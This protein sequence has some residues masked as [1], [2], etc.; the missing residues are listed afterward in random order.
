MS[1]TWLATSLVIGLLTAGQ[2]T[3]AQSVPG[4]VGSWALLNAERIDEAAPLP[5]ANARGLIIMDSAGHV[6]EVVTRGR[7][8]PYVKNQ[9]TPDE[10]LE[11][12]NSYRGFWGTYRA[13]EKA[14]R[15]EYRPQGAVNPNLMGQEL[16]RDYELKGD[17][18]TITSR[19]GDADTT[20]P[21]R[22]V[23]Q[24]IPP[25][26]NLSPAYRQV[27]GFWQWVGEKSVATATGATVTEGK[28]DPSI[29]VYAPS[30]LIGVHF[31]PANR[32]RLAGSTATPEEA[33]AS[34]IGY[35]GYT[36]VLTVHPGE[37][38]HHQV[39]TLA[40]GG[41][42]LLRR[43]YELVGNEIHLKFPPTVIQGQ[44][45]QTQVTLRR[46]SGESEMLGK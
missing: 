32:K 36:A 33:R 35:V 14:G 42:N 15:I 4:L 22:S 2:F 17:R 12:F 10:A 24:R 11:A 5:L 31:V 45:R 41:G 19:A 30:G 29:I 43:R 1:R 39:L 26:E 9:P 3:G 16:V 27:L 34:I 40:P 25:V 28:R 38:I 21:T 18:L 44:E 7:R 13:D 46:L 6:V 8:Q 20:V 37:V 23:W